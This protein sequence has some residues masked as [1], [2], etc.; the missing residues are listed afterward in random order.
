MSKCLFRSPL[1]NFTHTN[2]D[3]HSSRLSKF[4]LPQLAAQI[5]DHQ[6]GGGDL[7]VLPK[8]HL[9]CSLCWRLIFDIHQ[10]NLYM[11]AH[12]LFLPELLAGH[13]QVVTRL[14]VKAIVY[15]CLIAMCVEQPSVKYIYA[16]Q[17]SINIAKISATVW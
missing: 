4:G 15:V 10:L 17:R 3:L 8:W 9:I 5:E 7:E 14:G 16:C 6:I 13:Q 2:I 11:A 1:L 12:L